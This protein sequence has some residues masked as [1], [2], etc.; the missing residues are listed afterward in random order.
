M[1]EPNSAPRSID[2]SIPIALIRAR[3]A[4][5]THFRPLLANRGYTE[6]QWRVLRVLGEHG[7]LEPTQLA[8]KSALLMPSLTRILKSLEEDGTISRAIDNND[9]RR[10]TAAITPK[11]ARAMAAAVESTEAAYYEI[12]SQFGAENMK[13]LLDLLA[14]LSEVGR[15]D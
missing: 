13:Q 2:Q 5:M 14:K 3:E 4:V 6:Q 15:Q 11:A 10:S 8:A 9:R 12:E 7:P 1:T